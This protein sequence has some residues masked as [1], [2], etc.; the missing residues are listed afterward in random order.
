[1]RHSRRSAF[2]IRPRFRLLW[3][4]WRWSRSSMS[5]ARARCH[6]VSG[7]LVKR[8]TESLIELVMVLHTS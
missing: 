7:D 4:S 3:K 1:M 2:A 6:P 5:P 8:Q